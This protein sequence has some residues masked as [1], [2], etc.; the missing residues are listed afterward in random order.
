MTYDPLRFAWHVDE[1]V[2]GSARPGRYGDLSDDLERLKSEG[3]DTI[4]N[5]CSKKLEIPDDFGDH[6][7]VVHEPVVDGSPPDPEQLD[8]IIETVRKSRDSGRRLVVHCRGGV[9]RTA[10]ILIPVMMELLDMELDEA[11]QGLRKAGRYTQSM[12][13]WEFLQDWIKRRNR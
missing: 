7:E 3:V 4:I 8:R 6:F 5:L 9:G 2:A 10:T 1:S 11:I 13:Q 12:E